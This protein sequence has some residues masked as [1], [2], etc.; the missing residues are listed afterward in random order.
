MVF[1]DREGYRNVLQAKRYAVTNPVGL[2]L[3][4][5]NGGISYISVYV[6]IKQNGC[7]QVSPPRKYHFVMSLLF[8]VTKVTRFLLRETRKIRS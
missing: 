2:S 8:H 6:N 3:V 7:H 5:L 4:R 1:T